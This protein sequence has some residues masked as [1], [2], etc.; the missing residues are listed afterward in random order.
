LLRRF[1]SLGRPLDWAYPSNRQIVLLSGGFLLAALAFQV[2]WL[3]R[4]DFWTALWGAGWVFSTWA[5][6]RELDPDQPSNAFWAALALGLGLLVRLSD[7][8]LRGVLTGLLVSGVLMLA[9][10]VTARTSGRRTTY[11]DQ[12][13]LA[14]SPA[15]AAWFSGSPLWPLALPVALALAFDAYGDKNRRHFVFGLILALV[16]G[17]L[18]W[19]LGGSRPPEVWSVG[20]TLALVVLGV[21]GLGFRAREPALSAADDHQ[22]L[23][24]RRVTWA[25][26]VGIVGTLVGLALIGFSPFLAVGWVGLFMLPRRSSGWNEGSGGPQPKDRAG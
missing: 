7:W 14:A 19:L 10:R 18:T 16:G 6:G 24:P 25:R 21:V 20:F 17:L 11:P 3:G 23:E 4:V 8:T 2:L 26:V 5:L 15:V 13:V 9:A 1:T 22:P 12:F